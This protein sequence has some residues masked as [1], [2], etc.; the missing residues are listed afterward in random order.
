MTEN[1]TVGNMKKFDLDYDALGKIKPDII[2]LSG[3]PLGQNGP[4]A[5][6]VGFGPTTQA[7][8]G[9]CHLTGYPDSFPCGIGGTWPD[10]A[11]GTAM[12]F[13][14]LAALHYRDQTGAGAVPGS[15]DGRDGDH[16]D[17]GSDD[18]LF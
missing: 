5:K 15:V 9:M 13:F 1:Y 10:F 7:F 12:V 17:A 18:G 8:A 6:T 2:M 14:I 11:V 3:T 16:D 4:Y